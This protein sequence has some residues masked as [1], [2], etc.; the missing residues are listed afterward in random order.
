MI[1]FGT[2]PTLREASPWLR[3]ASER[4]RRILEVTERD[5]VIEGLPP[6]SDETRRRIIEQLT[7]MDRTSPSQ[8]PCE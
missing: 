7:A 3:D 2:G 4:H 6:L 8:A 5:S 1:D